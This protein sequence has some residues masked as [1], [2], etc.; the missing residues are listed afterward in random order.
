MTILDKIIYLADVIE[1][2]RSFKGVE[3]IR[4]VAR[5]DL[6]QAVLTA[7]DQNIRYIVKGGGVIHPATIPARNELLLKNNTY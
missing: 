3:D 1:P 6:D 5:I 7:L 2:G 4:K